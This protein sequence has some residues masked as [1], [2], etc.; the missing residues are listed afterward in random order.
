ME[1]FPNYT[2][3]KDHEEGYSLPYTFAEDG[4]PA[5]GGRAWVVK[6][7]FSN[8]KT[9][10][11]NYDEA[12][13]RYFVEEYGAP[14]VD[15]NNGQQVA[16]TNVVVIRAS[17][18]AIDDYGRMRVDL[19]GYSGDGWFA[20]G[21]K[22]VPITWEKKGLNDPLTYALEDGAP[23]TFGQGSSYVNIIPLSNEITVE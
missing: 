22:M 21:G 4:A 11:F 10:V 18:K 6:V 1:N 19:S 7:P 23:V 16:V 15:G 8:Y 20:C 17:C 5:G 13:G 2:F 12:T 9:G 14:L 3:R